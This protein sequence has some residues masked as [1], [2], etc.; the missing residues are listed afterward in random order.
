MARE[1][2][3]P[4]LENLEVVRNE[5]MEALADSVHRDILHLLQDRGA[6]TAGEIS[7]ELPLGLKETEQ[8]LFGLEA[9]ELLD[10]VTDEGQEYYLP[11]ARYISVKTEKLQG[12]EGI[13][14]V[15]EF[16]VERSAEMAQELSQVE[17]EDV[18]SGS[19]TLHQF[20]MSSQEMDWVNKRLTETFQEIREH[21]EQSSKEKDAHCRLAFFFYPIRD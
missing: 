20:R 16:L 5:Q 19:I 11:R 10:R 12:E 4:A 1:N 6:S 3:K 15:R 17:V 7:R 18:R 8:Y 9:V 2:L 14:L 21:L 13:N